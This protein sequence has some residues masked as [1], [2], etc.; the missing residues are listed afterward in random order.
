[1]IKEQQ[2]PEMN[3]L[4]KKMKKIYSII[5]RGH[6]VGEYDKTLKN[7]EQEDQL[8]KLFQGDVP[9]EIKIRHM[10]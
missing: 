7:I 9:Y 6:I 3:K 4:I 10:G 2:T 1:M 8:I 5:V